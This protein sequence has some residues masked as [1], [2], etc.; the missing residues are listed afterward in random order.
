M[1]GWLVRNQVSG[2]EEQ[3]RV[4]TC[5]G[6]L[7]VGGVLLEGCRVVERGGDF[8]EEDSWSLGCYGERYWFNWS[9]KLEAEGGFSFCLAEG[10]QAFRRYLGCW[11]VSGSRPLE[12]FFRSRVLSRP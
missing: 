9:R 6:C 12:R 8:S 7:A 2:L 5:K 10:E 1:H 4:D 11:R 3:S